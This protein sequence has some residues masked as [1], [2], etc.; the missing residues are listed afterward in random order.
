MALHG[1]PSL[2]YLTIQPINYLTNIHV[3]AFVPTH[4]RGP[5]PD[6]HRVPFSPA[7]H[8]R[9]AKPSYGTWIA[10]LY[11]QSLSALSIENITHFH[12][13][14]EKVHTKRVSRLISPD[15][16]NRVASNQMIGRQ[17]HQTVYQGLAY[18]YPVKWVSMIIG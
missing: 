7:K 15:C 12:S 17:Y 14:K 16:L 3:A 5:V 1:Y 6:S 9:Q 11:T 18:K 2:N 4:S 10:R 13:G 8:P